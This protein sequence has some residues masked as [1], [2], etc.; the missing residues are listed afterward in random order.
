T[1]TA[2][3]ACGNATSCSR[4]INVVDNTA[5]L[6]VC[7][8]VIAN[9]ECPA[10]PVFPLATATDLCD[11][12]PSVT[13]LDAT[14]P[15]LCPQEFS[16]TR[17]FTATD[18]CGN[19]TSCS[20]TI[21]VTDNTA[22]VLVC[23]TVTANVECPAL[24]I[25]PLA[26]A[27]DLC[28][29]IPTV[30]FVDATI[31]GICP[32]EFSVI[33]TWTAIDDCG[34]AAT[35]SRTIN[36]TDNTAPVITCPVS[37]TVTCV[38]DIPLPVVPTAFDLCSGTVTVVSLGDVVTNQ[39]CANRLTVTRTYRATDACANSA[40]CAQIITVFDDVLPTF[41]NV[42][43]N[44][45]VECFV[46]PAIVTPQAIDNC[47]GIVS[48]Q[49]VGETQLP[50]I[51]PT[52]YTLIRT[53]RATD[54]CGNSTLA[55][56]MITVLDT[57]APQF[58]TEPADVFLECN[59]ELN[60]DGFQIWL[61]NLG[62]SVASDCSEITWSFTNS[63]FIYDSTGC[64]ATFTRYIR[65]IAT[66]ECGNTSF[67]D[68]G[69]TVYD[70]TPPTFDVL[71]VNLEIECVEGSNS[72]L[73]LELWLENFGNAQVSDLCGDVVTDLVF[74]S[75][76]P[77]CGNTFIRTYEFRATD[78]CGNTNYVR[79]TFSIVDTTPPVI[80]ECPEGDFLLTCEFDVP[81]PDLSGVVATDNCGSVY[82]SVMT[83][84][85]GVGCVYWPMNVSYWYM[86]TDECGNMV[87][88]CDVPF[89][90]IDSIPPTYTGPDT[91][92]VLCVD[93]L[94][95][96]GDL[97]G[98]LAPY[99]FDN[100]Y[101]IIC[102][103][104]STPITGPN[105]VTYVVR[106][107]DLCGNWTEKFTVTFVA[108]GNCKPLCTAPQGIW[109]NVNGVINGTSTTEILEAYFNAFE[110]L[111]VGNFG[112][113]V[114]AASPE[115]VQSLLP[116]ISNTYQFGLGNHVF[117]STTNCLQPAKMLN[118]DGTLRNKLAA[119][120]MA[121]QLN[122]WYNKQY[123]ER[124]LAVQKLASLP[125]C[126]VDPVVMG[127]MEVDLVT[128]QGL[129]NLSNNYLAGLGAFP[130]GFGT[131]TNDAV[132]NI[133]SYYQ[134]C[135]LNNP[136]PNQVRRDAVKNRDN[137]YGL[138]LSPNPVVDEVTILFEAENDTELLV[139]FV[140]GSGVMSEEAVQA[141]EGYN[142]FKFSTQ[143][144]PSGVYTVVLQSDKVQQKLRMVKIS[145]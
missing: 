98:I 111:T 34:N 118:D 1:W 88:D 124:D 24:P 85:Q 131:M 102:I 11:P 40:T 18:A 31:P 135:Q 101:D 62:G 125:D 72:D 92:E 93:D 112:R 83:S 30:S 79:A 69:Y 38:T 12:L 3:D 89:L 4:T 36:V 132:N 113:T 116:G 108:V 84:V 44:I 37:Q 73:E 53:W 71:P 7:P 32:Q 140:N 120:L 107:K 80:V 63:P 2:V 23:P 103:S 78:E 55:T 59:S 129:V 19:A 17:T 10:L 97:T 142:T 86:A 96:P 25:F 28:D 41:V 46:V 47:T 82:V 9:I 50:G 121:L 130:T 106:A 95:G 58:T 14:I 134:N 105:F 144:L 35:C 87:S 127:L 128:V 15:G 136:C 20:V 49:F 8:T 139:R 133:N 45:T 54:V 94:P 29:A 122:I 6:L 143:K 109:G 33:R 104:D 91:L 74:I 76:V 60:E 26:T 64:G 39:I 99:F 42:P 65:F 43:P 123:N 100:C 110:S 75:N 77:G 126:L 56:Q 22:P 5:P 16:V 21:N 61:D 48:V 68:V 138:S 141:V 115:C 51:C 27:T 13:F 145:K 81:L 57:Y 137:L 90:V 70:L 114:S 66:D 67:R 52:L 117:D 119:N